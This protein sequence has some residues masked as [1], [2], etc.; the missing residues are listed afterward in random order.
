MRGLNHGLLQPPSM[1]SFAVGYAQGIPGLHVGR[2]RFV[3]GVHSSWERYAADSSGHRRNGR[4]RAGRVP[5]RAPEDQPACTRGQ[6]RCGVGTLL[7]LPSAM[8]VARR[9]VA[10]RL[11]FQIGARRDLTVAQAEH[12]AVV[13]PGI[14][15]SQ[16]RRSLLQQGML[17]LVYIMCDISVYLVGDRATQVYNKQSVILTGAACS[18][19]LGV[20][21]SAV[22]G[23]TQAVRETLELRSIV[24]LLP[25]ALCF[26]VSSLGLLQAF[27]YFDAA[28]IK[29]LGQLKLPM[30]ALFTTLF[31]SRRYSFKQWQMVLMICTACSSFTLLKMGGGVRMRTASMAGLCCIGAWVI[32]NVLA[33]V[34]IERAFRR[35]PKLP[36]AAMMTRLEAGKLISVWALWLLSPGSTVGAFYEGWD[37]TTVL[38]L[39]SLIC[40]EWL[41]GIMV[42][43][44]S[45]V[46]KAASKCVSLT[47]LYAVALS[48]GRQPMELLQVLGA[49]MIL[50]STGMFAW[51]SAFKADSQRSHVGGVLAG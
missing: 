34:L 26:G 8:C 18:C 10:P 6:R 32:C 23:G 48:T 5:G 36:F 3:P 42:K 15:N 1:F 7:M 11:H 16:S 35:S 17:C 50:Q 31:V 41:S 21:V 28:F 19:M 24:F 37:F 2:Q 27:R 46:A 33:T 12:D 47:A 51:E 39:T 43:R 30:T 20:L 44:L 49:L 22:R 29:L 4:L 40:D 25:V 9:R 38:V 13:H 45:S 14:A